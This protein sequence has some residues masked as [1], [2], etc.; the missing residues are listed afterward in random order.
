M[1]PMFRNDRGL[2]E[3]EVRAGLY[4]HSHLIGNERGW[5][6]ALKEACLWLQGHRLVRANFTEGN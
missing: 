5:E 6:A 2:T 4:A 3:L 1:T